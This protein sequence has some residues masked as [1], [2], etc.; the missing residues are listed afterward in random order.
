LGKH[1]LAHGSR[2]TERRDF[3][4]IMGQAKE[5]K[6]H[7]VKRYI[8]RGSAQRVMVGPSDIWQQREEK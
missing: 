2:G 8:Y 5:R 4:V 7:G 6:Q 1:C 3:R